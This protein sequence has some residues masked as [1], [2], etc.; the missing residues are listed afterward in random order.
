MPNLKTMIWLV[1]KTT[2]A[3]NEKFKSHIND[4]FIIKEWY[5]VKLPYECQKIAKK[6]FWK[7]FDIQKKYGNF[8]DG[9]VKSKVSSNSFLIP[10][11]MCM[12]W[13][14]LTFHFSCS[15]CCW[16]LLGNVQSSGLCS[17]TCVCDCCWCYTSK[18]N[19]ETSSNI[20]PWLTWPLPSDLD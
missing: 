14:V 8:P 5:S 11:I 6:S 19:T 10:P 13:R 20:Q 2:V 18:Q 15:L 1:W 3:T 16:V 17:D 9:Q 12:I 7:F 4:M